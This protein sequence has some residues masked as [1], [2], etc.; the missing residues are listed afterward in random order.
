MSL[1]L[2]ADKNPSN[3]IGEMCSLFPLN[4]R[5][6]KPKIFMFKSFFLDHLP[7]NIRTHL[8]REDVQD[9]GSLQPKLTRFGSLPL[10]GM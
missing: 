2:V 1:T 7:P 3:L 4:H 8:M 9:L 10:T 5:V 6:H